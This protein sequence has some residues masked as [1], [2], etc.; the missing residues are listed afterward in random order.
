[1]SKEYLEEVMSVKQDE[2]PNWS[3]RSVAVLVRQLLR[4]VKEDDLTVPCLKLPHE[5]AHGMLR[6]VLLNN[7]ECSSSE[8][9][10]RYYPELPSLQ[11]S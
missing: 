8:A 5:A 6:A 1:M 2:M 11:Q 4:N 9:E 3:D 10:L 7:Y